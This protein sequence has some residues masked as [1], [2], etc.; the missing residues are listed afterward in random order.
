[1]ATDSCEQRRIQHLRV[2]ENA[3]PFCLYPHLAATHMRA[4]ILHGPEMNVLGIAA[5]VSKGFWECRRCSSKL[6]LRW[7]AVFVF[8]LFLVPDMIMFAFYVV[9]HRKLKESY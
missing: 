3:M 8:A 6:H 9:H 4:S 7:S 2:T 1:M 5:A